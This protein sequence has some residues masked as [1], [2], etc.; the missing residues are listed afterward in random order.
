MHYT[1]DKYKQG[2]IQMK[3]ITGIAL[4]GALVLTLAGAVAFAAPG[5]NLNTA[6]PFFGAGGP[7]QQVN[8]TDEQKAQIA[9]WQQERLEH[10]KQVLQKQVEW[11]WIT[12]AQADE[13]I[14]FMEQRQKDGNFGWMGRGNGHMGRGAGMG[15]GNGNCFNNNNVPAQ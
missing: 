1:K 4:T 13:R 15:P 7:G 8:L 5:N 9:T 6:C 2:V 10:R 14:S 11:G 12:Q 3:K